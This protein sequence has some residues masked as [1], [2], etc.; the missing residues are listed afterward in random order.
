ML[1]VQRR[2]AEALHFVETEVEPFI[3]GQTVHCEIDWERRHDNMQQH[4]GQH[5]ISAILERDYNL[6]TLS[7]WLGADVSYIQ[8]DTQ[9]K[10]TNDQINKVERAC[11]DLIAAATP[12]T[13]NV[14]KSLNDENAPDEVVR[15]TRGLPEDHVGDIRVITIEGVE[16][17]MCCGTHVT[18]LAQLNCVKLLNIEKT[19]NKLILNFLVGNRVVKRLQESFERELRINNI[20][21]C[22]NIFVFI[23]FTIISI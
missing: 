3:V 5:L 23:D 16:S 9:A 20:V 4:S 1:N 18:N 11:N 8:L 13:V 19:K 6:Q 14:L 10:I 15:A 7:W 2:A 21:K 22:V 12:V 17:N